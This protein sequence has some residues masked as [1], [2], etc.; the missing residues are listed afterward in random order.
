MR[1]V[2]HCSAQWNVSSGLFFVFVVFCQK[3]SM[4]TILLLWKSTKP[5]GYG[6]IPNKRHSETVA[7]KMSAALKRAPHPNKRRS[8]AVTEKMSAAALIWVLRVFW[9]L[10]D[11]RTFKRDSKRQTRRT[12]KAH[13]IYVSPLIEPIVLRTLGPVGQRDRVCRWS[14]VNTVSTR[15]TFIAFY[16]CIFLVLLLLFQCCRLPWNHFLRIGHQDSIG[17]LY[18]AHLQPR[19]LHKCRPG[20]M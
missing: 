16:H 17:N 4:R 14:F 2:H 8:K 5:I 10:H 15:C 18:S 7:E 9:N 13:V 11:V 19:N 20:W 1:I 3:S 12:R 6:N